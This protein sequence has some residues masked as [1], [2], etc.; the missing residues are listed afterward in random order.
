V[1]ITKNHTCVSPEV[2]H[3]FKQRRTLW[4]QMFGDTSKSIAYLRTLAWIV[5]GS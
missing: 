5:I 4:H 3:F 2:T 1:V